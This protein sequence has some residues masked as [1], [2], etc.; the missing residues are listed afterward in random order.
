MYKCNQVEGRRERIIRRSTTISTPSL[1]LREARGPTTGDVEEEIK[2][3]IKIIIMKA[4][5]AIIMTDTIKMIIPRSK[6]NGRCPKTKREEDGTST[7]V[8]PRPPITTTRAVNNLPI[9][10]K[11]TKKEIMPL[12]KKR[13]Q[14]RHLKSKKVAQVARMRV[15]ANNSNTKSIRHY[16]HSN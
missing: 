5:E 3:I 7:K 10:K 9:T 8:R 16:H 11:A 1:S 2:V 12:S 6:I 15:L 4:K 14:T 13:N